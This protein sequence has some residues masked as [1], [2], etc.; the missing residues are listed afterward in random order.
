MTIVM[1]MFIMSSV[2]VLGVIMQSVIM[3]RVMAPPKHLFI[4]KIENEKGRIVKLKESN[5]ASELD[6]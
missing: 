1:T 4:W 2:V 5:P 3:L 6:K